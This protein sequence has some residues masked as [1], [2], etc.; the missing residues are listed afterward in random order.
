MVVQA[1]SLAIA[2]SSRYYENGVDSAASNLVTLFEGSPL[3]LPLALRPSVHVSY[4]RHKC[5]QRSLLDL[6]GADIGS[7]C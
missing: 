1:S 5:H 2:T 6:Q 4:I 7:E 3:L